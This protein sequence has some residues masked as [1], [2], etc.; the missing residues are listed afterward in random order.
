MAII[1]G[2]VQFGSPLLF[3]GTAFRERLYEAEISIPNLGRGKIG[4]DK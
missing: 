1:F 4:M 3:L 2:T